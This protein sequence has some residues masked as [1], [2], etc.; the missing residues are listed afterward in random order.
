MSTYY[1]T[2]T[3]GG[4]ESI[5][6]T[7]VSAGDEIRIVGN[8]T[9]PSV[10]KSLGCYVRIC[11][12]V[13]IKMTELDSISN[14]SLAVTNGVVF[15]GGSYNGVGFRVPAG[16]SNLTWKNINFN[17]IMADGTLAQYILR[18]GKETGGPDDPPV[19]LADNNGQ[20]D[21]L[22][23]NCSFKNALHGGVYALSPGV[24]NL[25]VRKCKFEDMGKTPGSNTFLHDG[26]AIGMQGGINNIIEDNIIN[27]CYGDAI[28]SWTGSQSMSHIIRRNIIRDTHAGKT[29]GT[30]ISFSSSSNNKVFA[31]VII[32]DNI[33]DNVF[34]SNGIG[35]GG[36]CVFEVF[37]NTVSNVFGEGFSFSNFVPRI[38]GK[39]YD[40][41]LKNISKR[42]FFA[43]WNLGGTDFIKN[44]EIDKNT[45]IGTTETSPKEF[46]LRGY[47]GDFTGWQAA[48]YDIN[49]IRA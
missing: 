27:G 44:V 21:V 37:G 40:N 25:T 26:H 34:D 16:V 4:L 12:P 48:G 8:I 47:H 1:V 23:E 41:E 15:D 10:N 42:F 45:Y 29:K 49:G 38:V 32:Q 24:K 17:G 30:A 7:R 5:P 2:Q 35:I 13:T 9:P 39:F 43:N 33:I 46:Y 20:F 22:V 36:D 19:P 6:W 28:A 3:N 11:K 18:F 14:Y 31:D